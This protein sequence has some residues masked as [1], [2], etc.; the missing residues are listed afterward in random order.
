MKQNWFRRL[1]F[2]YMPV[3]VAICATLLLISIQSMRVLSERSAVRSSANVVQNATQLLEQSLRNIEDAMTHLVL[4]EPRIAAYYSMDETNEASIPMYTA[5]SS[6]REMQDRLPLVDSIYLYKRED[7]T[8]LETSGLSPLAGYKDKLFIQDKL[9]S[10]E[11]FIWG[12]LRKW[13]QGPFSTTAK[14]VI[15]L[16]KISD[17]RSKGLLVVNVDVEDLQSMLARSTDIS[18]GYLELSDANGQLI[19]STVPEQPRV[20]NE[21][22]KLVSETLDYTGWKLEGG[23]LQPGLLGWIGSVLYISTLLGVLCIAIG[24]IWIIYVSRRHYR[25]VESLLRQISGLSFQKPSPPLPEDKPDEFQTISLALSSL[26]DQSNRLN[27]ENEENKLFKR[28]HQFQ[29]LA[30]GRLDPSSNE[31]RREA[32]RLGLMMEGPCIGILIE[33]DRYFVDVCNRYSD[34]DRRIYK[35][36]LHTATEESLR[37]A[38]F[39]VCSDWLAEHRYGV[40]AG[41]GDRQLDSGMLEVALE[42][43]R[44]WI[45]RHLPFTVTIG[46]GTQVDS[47]TSVSKSIHFAK[48]ALAYKMPLGLNRVIPY[49]SLPEKV[50]PDIVQELQRMKEIA[51]L[52][53]MGDPGWEYETDQLLASLQG[54]EYGSEQV[55]N[56][57]YMLLFH[58][59]RELMDIPAE[60]LSTWLADSTRLE[61]AL[62][63]AET[64]NEIGDTVRTVLFATWECL[65]Q[66]RESKKNHSILYEIKQFIDKYYSDPNL[67]LGLLGE[68]FGLHIT[69]ISRLFKEEFGVKF[70]DYVNQVRVQ[71]AIKRIEQDQMTVAE[72]AEAV[73]FVHPQT[74]TRI[75]KKITGHTPGTY[76]KDQTTDTH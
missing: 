69:S 64:L 21:R 67:S 60:Q 8:V 73:G 27:E 12:D 72:I 48:E 54:G 51:R 6:L 31:Y 23:V 75:F 20:V 70:V 57:L 42:E 32:R 5:A 4:V 18:S 24:I 68:R 19:A 39:S 62:K 34:E 55:I 17:L 45:D 15:S 56:L 53:R 52:L 29:R 43:L 59:Q 26:L 50:R 37:S 14:R 63:H 61:N 38:G 65:G 2:S 40:I 3:F 35:Y 33:V 16:T 58:V 66:W 44:V 25:P 49:R 7:G 71:E 36:A 13:Q 30:E 22:K 47:F 11:G 28:A 9:D 10:Y 46:V 1:L 76:R 41:T 74:F